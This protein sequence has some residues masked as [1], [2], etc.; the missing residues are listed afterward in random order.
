MRALRDTALK[1]ELQ[2]KGPV[3]IQ[4]WDDD[5]T[6]ADYLGGFVLDIADILITKNRQPRALTGPLNRAEVDPDDDFAPPPSY[7]W[8]EEE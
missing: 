1:Q 4:V 3:I 2:S 7:Q 8:F 5:E 6:S